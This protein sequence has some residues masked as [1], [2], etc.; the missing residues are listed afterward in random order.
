MTV[1]TATLDATRTPTWQDHRSIEMTIVVWLLRAAL[2]ALTVDA[3]TH[4][5]ASSTT[6]LVTSAALAGFAMTIILALL[7]HERPGLLQ[8]VEALALFGVG[9]HVAGHVFAL[10][11]RVPEFDKWFHLLYTP[12][13]PFSFY[14]LARGTHRDWRGPTLTPSETGF[15]LFVCTIAVGTLWE[16]YEFAFDSFFGT[17]MQ[18][19]NTDTMGDLLADVA[20]GI[21]GGLVA[22][23][24]VAHRRHP[25]AD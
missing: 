23:W 10:Y 17:A 21:L 20:G 4:P 3:F 5:L 18:H 25:R 6:G 8:I 9:A 11:D 13:V 7:P 12:T 14:A 2:L 16:G 24:A 22:R 19:G 1:G 15:A